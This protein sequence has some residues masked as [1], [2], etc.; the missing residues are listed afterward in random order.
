MKS[1]NDILEQEIDCGKIIEIFGD[2]YP[3]F[4]QFVTTQQDPEWHAEGNVLVHTNMVIKE[5]YRL[6]KNESSH[7]S[8][9]EKVILILS[10]C[11]HD[12]AK[13]LCTQYREI[14]GKERVV[15]P[16]HEFRGA[17]LLFN[18]DPPLDLEPADWLSVIQ[19]TA[20][21]HIPKL[22]VIKNKPKKDYFRLSRQVPSMEL[23]YYLEMA[24]MLGRTCN[25]KQDQIE[26][27]ELFKI[28]ASE[29]GIWNSD[30][31]NEFINTIKENFPCQA[32]E[33]HQRVL[34]HA[35]I[36]LEEERI[37]MLEEEIPIAYNYM[38]QPHV[39]ILCGIAGSGKSTWANNNKTD[40]YHIEMDKIRDELSKGRSNQS[41]NSEVLRVAHEKLKC[42]LRERKNVLWDATNY[43]YDFRKRIIETSVAY[44]AFTE[45][46]VF[47]KPLSRLLK[48]NK[49][50][51]H[52]VPEEAINSM[53][54]KFQMP[55]I[56]EAHK[57]TIMHY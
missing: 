2:Q 33:F 45:I 18:L 47:Q 16:N 30:P 22:L 42:A 9:R 21:H 25:D 14:K 43:R 17:S 52:S 10:A 28:E 53:V 4:K 32:D 57:L 26:I 44:G 31:Y 6:T 38:E 51:K 48:D 27:L 46:I 39:V 23:I 41:N 35:K 19:L 15:A 50:R 8:N 40:Y 12:Y 34:E 37:H 7:L 54:L 1:I 49:S 3:L 29:L 24:D 20:Y 11:F 5:A 56:G 55:E 36:H 13:P